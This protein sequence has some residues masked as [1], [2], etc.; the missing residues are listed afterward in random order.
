M[1][2]I[3]DRFFKNRDLVPHKV[4]SLSLFISIHVSIKLSIR[5]CKYLSIY[6]SIY[7][8]F[9]QSAGAVEYTDCTSAER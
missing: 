4:K 9:A 3:L 5:I 1:N 2:L 6:L 8:W 7:F